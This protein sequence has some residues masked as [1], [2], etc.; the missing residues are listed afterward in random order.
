MEFY[1]WG[2]KHGALDASNIYRFF[3][4]YPFTSVKT[5]H[6]RMLGFLL[7]KFIACG[8][9]TEANKCLAIIVK[10]ESPL[11]IN[12]TILDISECIFAMAN[13]D[14][15]VRLRFLDLLSE[16]KLNKTMVNLY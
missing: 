14:P 10:S 16:L 15:E 3:K 9:I 12:N 6:L 4:C 2:I 8:K 13:A 5:R 1:K 7:L 11:V